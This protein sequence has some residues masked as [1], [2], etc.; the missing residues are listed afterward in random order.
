MMKASADTRLDG[1]VSRT[2]QSLQDATPSS[3][4]R[5]RRPAV[6]DTR[7]PFPRQLLH[8]HSQG[9]SRRRPPN[10]PVFGPLCFHEAPNIDAPCSH[11]YWSQLRPAYLANVRQTHLLEVGVIISRLVGRDQDQHPLLKAVKCRPSQIPQ[12][13]VPFPISPGR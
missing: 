10:P 3:F 5:L 4:A 11:E 1:Q 2:G 6:E 8:P 9:G 12:L 13:S 7:Q